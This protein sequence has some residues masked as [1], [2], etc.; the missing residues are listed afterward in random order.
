[1]Y[2]DTAG[3]DNTD[4][5]LKI[6]AKRGKELAINEVVVASSTGDTAYKA[7]E[8][9]EGFQLTVVTY[10]CGFKEPFKNRMPEEA[11]RD[12]EKKGIRVFAG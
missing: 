3:K 1:M 9:F 11:R 6:A 12:I 10:H 2:F 8:V 4:Q 5:T 7:I